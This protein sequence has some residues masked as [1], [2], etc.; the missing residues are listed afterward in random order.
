[1][2]FL[3]FCCRREAM[4][5]KMFVALKLRARNGAQ[6]VSQACCV[7]QF[8]MKFAS[9]KGRYIQMATATKSQ[10][11]NTQENVVEAPQPYPVMAHC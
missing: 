8:Q 1:M 7:R 9:S 6:V 10:H 4:L 11:A 3:P 2:P 5:S